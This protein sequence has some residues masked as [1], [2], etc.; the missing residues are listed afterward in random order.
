M[1]LLVRFQ[2][3]LQYPT[4]SVRDSP[5]GPLKPLRRL[6]DKRSIKRPA[7]IVLDPLEAVLCEDP[8][9]LVG[10]LQA[11]YL[12]GAG[13]IRLIGAVAKR[14]LH[15]EHHHGVASVRLDRDL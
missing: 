13:P 10:S 7:G 15:E 9:P 14:E 6:R 11:L 12:H 4:P 1:H 8:P 3:P 5:P 2:A